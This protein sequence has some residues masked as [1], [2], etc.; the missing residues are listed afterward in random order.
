VLSDGDVE[1]HDADAVGVPELPEHPV[2]VGI[3]TIQAPHDDDPRGLGLLEL[4]PDRL[5][6]NLRAG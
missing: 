1:R 2:E 6:A 3:L 4:R 5:R